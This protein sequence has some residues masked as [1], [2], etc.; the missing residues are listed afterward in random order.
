VNNGPYQ[1]GSSP[2]HP[3][4]HKKGAF[5]GEIISA[6]FTPLFGFYKNILNIYLIGQI[7]NA[8]IPLFFHWSGRFI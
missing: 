6:V 5:L 1:I 4:L 3:S 7:H 8:F 2:F